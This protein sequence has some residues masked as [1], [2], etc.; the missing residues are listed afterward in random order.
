MIKI[1]NRTKNK[2]KL[3]KVG[4]GFCISEPIFY[5]SEHRSIDKSGNSISKLVM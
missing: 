5:F 2:N 1:D 3:T 4:R